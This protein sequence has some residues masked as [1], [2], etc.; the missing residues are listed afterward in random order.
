MEEPR[1]HGPVVFERD[2]HLS[3]Q[4][5]HPHHLYHNCLRPSR[6][7][8]GIDRFV[9]EQAQLKA[10]LELLEAGHHISASSAETKRGPPGVNPGSTRGQPG[11]HPWSTRGPSGIKP[12]PTR[13]QPG[14]NPES[15]RGQPGVNPGSTQGQPG[16]NPGSIC[17]QPGV[18]LGSAQGQ[19]R[20]ELQRP[21][22]SATPPWAPVTARPATAMP[23][24]ACASARF[25]A[26]MALKLGLTLVH[27]RAQFEDLLDTSITL[28]LNL[29]TFGTHPR[30]TLCYMGHQVS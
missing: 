17:G 24:L 8:A 13:G 15:T 14:I 2:E 7:L 12:G 18:N 3:V 5:E 29:S 16:I 1:L 10:K 27:F 26:R 30:V 9:G 28:E 6:A 22:I 4:R 20:V 21:T 23:C 19:P 11:V 25:M